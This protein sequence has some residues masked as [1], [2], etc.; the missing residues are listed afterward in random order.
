MTDTSLVGGRLR[1]L[2]APLGIPLLTNDQKSE[3]QADDRG[4][5]EGRRE[6]R[7]YLYLRGQ[8]S[9]LVRVAVKATCRYS[10]LAIAKSDPLSCIRIISRARKN[11]I[12]QHN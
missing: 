12:D 11:G 2:L 7:G 4:V 10:R 9:G 1:V 3:M 6:Q 5:A 8:H